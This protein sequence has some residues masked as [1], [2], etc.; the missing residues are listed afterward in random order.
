MNDIRDNELAAHF[1]HVA[2]SLARL[3][4]TAATFAEADHW[5]DECARFERLSA[6]AATDAAKARAVYRPT[7]AYEAS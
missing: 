1:N 5:W 3:A 6:L 7:V 4:A 2:A